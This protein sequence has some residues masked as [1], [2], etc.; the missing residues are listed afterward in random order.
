M[1]MRASDEPSEETPTP[2]NQSTVI[3]LLGTIADT[4]WRMFVPTITGIVGGY[5][6]DESLGTKPWLF[7]GGTI[8]GCIVAGLLI[9]QQLQKKI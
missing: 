3:L 2:P 9:K 5:M 6:L 7:A 8:L 1:Y 4:T